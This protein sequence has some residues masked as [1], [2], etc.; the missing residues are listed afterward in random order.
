MSRAR[1]W[2]IVRWGAGV[3]I[4]GLAGVASGSPAT[5]GTQVYL[6]RGLFDVSTGLDGLAAKL[7]RRGIAATVASYTSESEVAAS[8]IRGFKAGTACPVVIVGHSLG[9]DA[10]ISVAETLKSAG[11]PVA[12]IVAFSPAH[13]RT[14]PGN[15]ARTVNYYQSNSSMWN[16]VYSA[17]SGGRGSIRNVDLAR[18]AAV[19]HFNIEKLT[20]LHGEAIRMIEGLGGSCGGAGRKGTVSAGPP[21]AAQQPSQ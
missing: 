11:V 16:N 8:A 9:A 20:R 4:A 13:A 2:S 5:A 12:L 21:G 18:Q 6:M 14:V 17:G 3:L 19:D 7:K 10:A 15:V 1:S